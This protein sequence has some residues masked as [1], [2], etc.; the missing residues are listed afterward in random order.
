MDDALRYLVC[1]VH[2]VSKPPRVR[3]PAVVSV[4][5]RSTWVYILCRSV[6]VCGRMAQWLM[7]RVCSFATALNNT[8]FRGPTGP[9]NKYETNQGPAGPT[10]HQQLGVR[11][12]TLARYIHAFYCNMHIYLAPRVLHTLT[13]NFRSTCS[14]YLE[15]YTSSARYIHTFSVCCR[16]PWC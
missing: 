10:K 3:S 5:G 2:H 16:T 14:I 4:N 8:Y 15:V 1:H 12:H 6:S 9:R 7:Q 13:L 11:Q